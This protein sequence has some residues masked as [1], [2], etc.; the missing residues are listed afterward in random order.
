VYRSTLAVCATLA[1]LAC[2]EVYGES[3][4]VPASGRGEDPTLPWHSSPV[5]PQEPRDATVDVATDA[6]ILVDATT[7]AESEDE[8]L[9]RTITLG[10]GA[11]VHLLFTWKRAT[12]TTAPRDMAIYLGAGSP[13]L[14]VRTTGSFVEAS[15]YLLSWIDLDQEV[16]HD[17]RLRRT[18]TRVDVEISPP[19]GKTSML[20]Q[21]DT[22]DPTIRVVLPNGAKFAAPIRLD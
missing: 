22:T 16:T 10:D 5:G 3:K 17:L 20:A 7:D 6:T 13:L 2:S 8:L 12:G 1:F 4:E 9:A 11:D 19:L 21:T 15:V 18:G 14:T